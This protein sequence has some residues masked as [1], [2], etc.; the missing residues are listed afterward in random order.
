M[1]RTTF[2]LII[3]FAFASCNSAKEVAVKEAPEQSE[4][5]KTPEKDARGNYLK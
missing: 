4:A 2:A 5:P 1:K 3:L